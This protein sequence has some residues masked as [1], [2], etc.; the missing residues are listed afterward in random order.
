MFK[1]H[2]AFTFCISGCLTAAQ[3]STVEFMVER[4]LFLALVVV[5]VQFEILYMFVVESNASV[6]VKKRN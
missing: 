6:L 3:H 1:I 2:P 5:F 4:P